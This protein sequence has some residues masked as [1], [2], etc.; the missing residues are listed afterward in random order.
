M[1]SKRTKSEK[2]LKKSK[3]KHHS[4]LEKKSKFPKS[5]KKEEIEK[6][7]NRWK[8]R[9]NKFFFGWGEEVEELKEK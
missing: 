3:L 1:L 9:K 7:M 5:L 8:T 2:K 6:R 4:E